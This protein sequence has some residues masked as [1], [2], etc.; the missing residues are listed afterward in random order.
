MT[1][2]LS[3]LSRSLTLFLLLLGVANICQARIGDTL[4]QT[5]ERYGKPVH[6]AASNEFVM[7]KEGSYYV[8]VHFHDG[9]TD[10]INY[11]KAGSDTSAKRVFSDAEIEMLLK[12]NGNGQTWKGSPAKAGIQEWKT[13]DGKFLAVCSESKSLVIKTADYLKR[14]E[15]AAKKK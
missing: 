8:T 11:V 9:K 3:H 5:I 4:D 14:L 10:A 2:R 1:A 15:E 13:E 7:F 6:K 12:I